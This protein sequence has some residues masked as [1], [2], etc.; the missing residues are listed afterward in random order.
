MFKTHKGFS[1]IEILVV[2]VIIGITITFT[3]LAFGDFGQARKIKFECQKFAHLTKLLQQRATLESKPFG[4]DINSNSYSFLI[5][6]H[7][8]NTSNGESFSWKKLTRDQLFQT[9]HIPKNIKLHFKGNTHK[10][11]III[12]PAGIITPFELQFVSTEPICKIDNTE[13]G[14]IEITNFD[15]K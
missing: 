10:P 1:L 13:G 12:S 4:I 8:S 5:F 15:K 2:M 3:L 7:L 11:Q 9:K 6:S 14:I